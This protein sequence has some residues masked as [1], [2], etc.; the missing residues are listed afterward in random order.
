MVMQ[1]Q[2][3]RCALLASGLIVG[4]GTGWMGATAARAEVPVQTLR[5][6]TLS[7]RVLMAQVTFEPPRGDA[8]RDT[9]GGASR[10]DT[11]STLTAAEASTANAPQVFTL[12]SPTNAQGLTLAEHPQFFIYVPTTDAPSLFFT[13]K[14]AEGTVQYQATLPLQKYDGVI[15]V[16]LPDSAPKLEAG[17][18]YQWGAALLCSGRLRPD[19]PFVSGWVKRVESTPALAQQLT[20]TMAP[21]E[22]AAVY[23]ANGLWY[24]MLS[25]LAQLRQEQPENAALASNWEQVLGAGGLEAIATKPVVQP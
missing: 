17:K 24:D 4:L 5:S 2:V 9:R 7:S 12:L 6:S 18:S 14:D 23:G 25:T 21:L 3:K 1:N 15:Q 11:C 16:S 19:S 22:R 10:G 8:P 20:A 13:L